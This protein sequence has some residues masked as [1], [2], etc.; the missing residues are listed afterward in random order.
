MTEEEKK[1]LVAAYEECEALYMQYQFAKETADRYL[2][3][4]IQ[5]IQEL[6]VLRCPHRKILGKVNNENK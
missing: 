3:K 6:P 1:S 5:R 4:Y 2:A